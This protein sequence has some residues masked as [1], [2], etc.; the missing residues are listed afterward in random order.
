MPKC[1]FTNER[2]EKTRRER[3]QDITGHSVQDA[4]KAEGGQWERKRRNEKRQGGEDSGKQASTQTADKEGKT[5]RTPRSVSSVVFHERFPS[6]SQDH[7]R[8]IEN[9]DKS[10]RPAPEAPRQAISTL[11]RFQEDKSLSKQPALERKDVLLNRSGSGAAS[12]DRV[13]SPP[14][15]VRTPTRQPIAATR[16]HPVRTSR[17]SSSRKLLH[18]RADE[19]RTT[20]N[21]KRVQTPLE[22]RFA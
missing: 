3:Q 11:D 16:L 2:N 22:R 20:P 9:T 21:A 1:G 13:P 19:A 8:R 10:R 7:E 12:L 15:L 4:M 17:S 18:G 14:N 5:G 6:S